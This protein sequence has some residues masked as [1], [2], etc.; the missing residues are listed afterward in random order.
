MGRQPAARRAE[1]GVRGAR[2]AAQR[3]RLVR[4]EAEVLAHYDVEAESERLVLEHLGVAVRVVRTG[5]GPPVLLLHGGGM[6]ATVWAP[7]LPHLAGRSLHLVDLPG[8]GLSDPF[9]YTGVDIVAHQEAFAGSVL[10]AL[11]LERAAL[12]GSSLGGMYALRFALAAPHRVTAAAIVS[13]P[14]VL[15]PGARVPL[16]MALASTRAGR[17][18]STRSPAPSAAMTRRILSTMGGDGAPEVPDVFYDALGAATAIAARANATMTPALFRWRTPVPHAAVTDEELAACEVP[19]LLLW[20]D[21]DRVQ[22]VDAAHRAA[23]VL[24]DA[25]VEVVPG[26]HGVWVEQPARCGE[27]LTAFLAEVEQRPSG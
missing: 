24:P 15:L 26:G 16:A 7:L 9:D 12:V 5:E 27:L 22:G 20:G 11:G 1:D 8:C 14:G 3:A 13:A 18:L 25:R 10:D 17:A 6:A 2:T 23:A 19:V 21:D 4:A